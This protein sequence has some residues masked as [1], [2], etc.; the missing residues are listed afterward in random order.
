[1]S[2]NFKLTD[3]EMLEIV[4]SVSIEVS[5]EEDYVDLELE[6][7]VNGKM[8]L[9]YIE[10]DIYTNVSLDTPAEIYW[11]AEVTIELDTIDI[12]SITIIDEEEEYIMSDELLE[13]SKQHLIETLS[14][15]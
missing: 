2:E 10:A 6:S 5:T 3:S 14:Y 8:Y 4:Q 11:P 15:V 9:I 7:Y 12:K 1:M 13:Q